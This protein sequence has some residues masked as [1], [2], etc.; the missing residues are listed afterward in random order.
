MKYQQ[1]QCGPRVESVASVAAAPRLFVAT[2]HL[3][4]P[5]NLVTMMQFR[6]TVSFRKTRGRVILYLEPATVA[7]WQF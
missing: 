5:I 1:L 4:V 6:F 3:P 2:V 7:L